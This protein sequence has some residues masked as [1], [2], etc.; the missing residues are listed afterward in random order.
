RGVAPVT[1]G[2]APSAHPSPGGGRGPSPPNP[3]EPMANFPLHTVDR[4][5][6]GLHPAIPVVGKDLFSLLDDPVNQALGFLVA[7]ITVVG[8]HDHLCQG[9][10]R[11]TGHG[12]ASGCPR[13]PVAI[14]PS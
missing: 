9:L 1:D 13:Q 6:A 14:G 7:V 12:A 8:S 4:L 11:A 5:R 10:G 2:S 3:P